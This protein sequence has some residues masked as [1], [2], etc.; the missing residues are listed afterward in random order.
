MKRRARRS[1]NRYDQGTGIDYDFLADFF[2]EAVERH[3][4]EFA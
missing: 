1:S 4:E 3:L 2:D